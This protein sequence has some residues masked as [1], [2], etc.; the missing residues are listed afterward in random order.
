MKQSQTISFAAIADKLNTDAPFALSASA[1]SGLPVSY[2]VV[3]GPATVSGNTV[4]LTGG[5][6][7]VT[8]R[9]SQ[10][11]NAQYNP[12]PDVNRSFAVTAINTGP[13]FAEA[14]GLLVVEAEHFTTNNPGTGSAAA[15]SWQLYSDGNASGGQAMRTTGT[16][17]ST[18]EN[19]N[20]PRLDYD[21]EFNT[22]G[23][24]YIWV[25]MIGPNGS[26]NSVHVGLDN[27]PAT[28]GYQGLSLTS[29]SWRWANRVGTRLVT[30]NITTPGRR[31]LNVWMREDGTRIDKIVMTRSSSYVPGGTGPA[32]SGPCGSTAGRAAALTLSA[33]PSGWKVD[34]AWISEAPQ[35]EE[36]FLLE[37]SADGVHF[38][39]LDQIPGSAGGGAWADYFRADPTPLSGWN[40]Y[41]VTRVQADGQLTISGVAAVYLD[42]LDGP[43][44]LFPNPVKDYLTVDLRPYAGQEVRLLMS[45]NAGQMLEDRQLQAAPDQPLEWDMSRYRNGWYTLYIQ[46]KGRLPV[47]A[48]VVVAKD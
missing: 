6:G 36:W 43:I 38:E 39:P 15:R 8:I 20:G 48:K 16:G 45:N 40:H 44:A 31:T 29:S 24:Y 32:E 26:D 46:V 23:T 28:L 1:S 13:C 4:T 10:A 33:T 35:P 9:A 19:I 11:G 2:A 47:A 42:Q 34:L 25:R 21:V 12:A 22:T 18:G 41:R 7:T 30:V 37:R 17:V 3:S 14:N 27:V 5:T